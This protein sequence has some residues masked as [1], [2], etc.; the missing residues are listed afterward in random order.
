MVTFVVEWTFCCLL[1]NLPKSFTFGEAAVVAQ[2]LTLFL[3]NSLAID[4]PNALLL[5]NIQPQDGQ[6]IGIRNIIQL[7]VLL[8]FILIGFMKALK[9]RRITKL[10]VF[11]PLTALIVLGIISIPVTQPIP[12]LF[13][14]EFLFSDLDKIIVLVIFGG[15]LLLTGLICQWQVMRNKPTSTSTRKLF[16]FVIVIVFLVGLLLQRLVLFLCAGVSF[17]IFLLLEAIRVGKV[18]VLAPV[19]EQTVKSF[20]DGQDSGL[21]ALTPIYLLVGC[22]GPLFLSPVAFSGPILP[23]LSGV[24]SVGI[25]D[26]FASVVGSNSGRHHWQ[27]SNKSIEGTVANALSQLLAIGALIFVGFIPPWTTAIEYAV[28]LIG[29]IVNAMIEAKTDQVDNLVVPLVTFIVF[30]VV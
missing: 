4:F 19:L 18:E 6:E 15:L 12:I 14:L 25:G 11:I 29:V 21:I 1:H 23:L 2:G 17:S 22:A 9:K 30:S 3:F 7:G 5:E 24:L 27:G 16:H 13:V 28:C 20:V 8:I 10:Y 26:S